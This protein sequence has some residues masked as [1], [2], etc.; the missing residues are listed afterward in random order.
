M[1]VRRCFYR[2]RKGRREEQDAFRNYSA[3]NFF[4]KNIPVK[5]R[6][7]LLCA[8]RFI[9]VIELAIKVPATRKPLLLILRTRF[10]CRG[11]FVAPWTRSLLTLPHAEGMG[12]NSPI[13]HAVITLALPTMFARALQVLFPL[14]CLPP[15]IH[16]LVRPIVPHGQHTAV[17]VYQRREPEL[18][19]HGSANGWH[20]PPSAG[21]STAAL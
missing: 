17:V 7:Y 14:P 19:D 13:Y 12:E 9:R 16:A 11:E 10:A 15:G 5:P 1:L 18:P 2:P 4:N 3:L 8:I 20:H 21:V 6:S